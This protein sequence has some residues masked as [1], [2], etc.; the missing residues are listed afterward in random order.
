LFMIFWTNHQN[1]RFPGQKFVIVLAQL[2]HVP[3]A[4]RSDKTAIEYQDYIA[5]V[6]II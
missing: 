2:R 4:E 6:L 3:A 1:F 5:L